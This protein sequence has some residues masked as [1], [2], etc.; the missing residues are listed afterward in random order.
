[1]Y[2][3]SKLTK[4]DIRKI[5]IL[6]R[7]IIIICLILTLFALTI[8]AA[9]PEIAEFYD[10]GY[11]LSLAA[12]LDVFNAD[13]EQVNA[14]INTDPNESIPYQLGFDE[15]LDIAIKNSDYIDDSFL[16]FDEIID[17]AVLNNDTN[18]IGLIA[19]RGS[20][21]PTV[22]VNLPYTGGGSSLSSYVYSD[23]KFLPNSNGTVTM[24]LSG[25]V[26]SGTASVTVYLYDSHDGSL[27][28]YHSFGNASG[29]SNNSPSPNPFTGLNTSHYYYYF[30]TKTPAGTNTLNYTLKVS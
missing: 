20:N 13:I 21:P 7:T 2:E 6:V 8:A 11:D 15:I 14:D 10:D 18:L 28:A 19:S 26:S 25:T 24:T 16:T 29:W 5:K 9:N 27:A 4:G 17:A 1:M 30:I 23:V 3:Y 22:S 12:P